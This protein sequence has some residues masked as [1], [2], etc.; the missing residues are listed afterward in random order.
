MTSTE[1]NFGTFR[2]VFSQLEFDSSC[3][4]APNRI[5]IDVY[6]NEIMLGCH[7]HVVDY[8]L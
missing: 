7:C 3:G 5:Q 4:L 8:N 6:V 1:Y 2:G